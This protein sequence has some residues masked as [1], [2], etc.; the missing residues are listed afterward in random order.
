MKKHIL[1]IVFILF[2]LGNIAAQSGT[3]QWINYSQKYYKFPVT[4]NGIYKISYQTLFNAGINVNAINPLNFQVFGRGQE[5]YIF[6]N[7]EDDEIFD[8][9]DYILVYGQKNDGYF[10]NRMFKDTLN[11]PNPYY[12]MV[13]D[14]SYYFVT[15][16]SSKSNRRIIEDTDNN[17]TGYTAS[18]YFNFEQVQ[19]LS[20]QY[21]GGSTTAIDTYLPSYSAGEGWVGP[22]MYYSQSQSYSFST[23]S[24]YAPG[25]NGI[26]EATVVGLTNDQ[27]NWGDHKLLVSFNNALKSDT[28]YE[29]HASLKFKYSLAPA[30]WSTTSTLKV[31]SDGTYTDTKADRSAVGYVK[32]KYPR[33]FDLGNSTSI[34]MEIMNGVSNKAYLLM[35]NFNNQSSTAWIFDLTN[36]YK[37][38]VTK[39]GGFY[40]ALVPNTVSSNKKCLLTTE[41][42]F[43]NV[44][45]LE[46]AIY[47]SNIFTNYRNL[48]QINGGY[49]YYILTVKEFKT[50]A[51]AYK[52]YRNSTGYKAVVIDIE[53][54]YMQYS[55]GIRKHPMAI[56]SFASD[57][58]K[59]WGIKPQYFFLMG[60]SIQPGVPDSKKASFSQDNSSRRNPTNYNLNKIPTFGYPGSDVFLTAQISDS[61]L[62]DPDIPLGRIS[63]TTGAKITEY[64]SKVQEYEAN[65]H[66]YWMKR[67]LHFGGGTDKA[68]GDQFATY[69]NYYKSIIEDTCF[70]GTVNTYL[71]NTTDPLQVNVS[72]SIRTNIND[73]ASIMTFFGHAYGEGFDQSIDAPESYTNQGKYPLIIANSCLIGN[74]HL[75]TTSSGS[76]T[77][78]LAPNRG[79]IGFLA[80]VSLGIPTPLNQYSTELYRNL[81]KKQYGKGIGKIM[82]GAIRNVQKPDNILLSDDAYIEDVC[83]MMTL[84]CDPAIVINSHTK[85]DYTLYGQNGINQPMVSVNPTEV[86]SELSSF[87]INMDIANIGKAI[88]DSL[89][90]R[91][92]RKFPNTNAPD[93]IYYKKIGGVKYKT[94]LQ[95]SLPVDLI[96]GVGTNHFSILVDSEYAISELD[97]TNNQ[98]D[99]DINIRS[100]D[101]IPV[102]PYQYAIVPKKSLVLKASTINPLAPE[103]KYIFQIDT[104]SNFSSSSPLFY[105]AAITKSGG[106]VSW[107][108]SD[109]PGLANVFNSLSTNTT[110]ATPTVFFWR[111]SL[112]STYT[113]KFNWKYSSF[114][115]VQ[116][117][118]GWG[119]AHYQQIDDDEFKFIEHDDNARSFS[120]LQHVSQ[121][122]ASTS[123]WLTAQTTYKIDGALQGYWSLIGGNLL[124]VAV[125]DQYALEPWEV[126][127]KPYYNQINYK[128]SY[129]VPTWSDK[130]YWYRSDR[131]DDSTVTG[132][133]KLINDANPG[134]YILMYNFRY[135]LFKEN[136]NNHGANGATFKSTL[137]ALG[138]SVDSLNNY[139][140]SVGSC[141]YPYILIAQKGNLSYT[142]EKFTDGCGTIG[143]N[144]SMTNNWVN[145]SI[146]SPAIG[147]A[148]KWSSLHWE[149]QSNEI[150]NL[151]DTLIL[152]VIGIDANNNETVIKSYV[153]PKD[154][155]LSLD[156]LVDASK[157]P[158]MRLESYL[159]DDSMHTPRQLK[160]M[161]V[162]Y[163][164]VTEI[165]VSPNIV[166]SI[167]SDSVQ[168]G[169]DY[170]M[171]LA[172]TNVSETDADTLQITYWFSDA[173]LTSSTKQYKLLP[174]IKAGNFY[175]DTVVLST[176]ELNG[177][178]HMWY[179][180]NPYT[181][182]RPWQAE[183]YHFNNILETHFSV[184]PDKTNP[185]LDVAFDGV[186]IIN[187]DIV[188][189]TALISIQL[190]DEN[191]FLALD[192]ASL[193]QIYIK[194]PNGNITTLDSSKYTFYPGSL[195]E[196]KSK[197]EIKGDYKIEG[198][199]EL[200]IR[201]IDRSANK[202]GK[203]DGNYDYRIEFEIVLKSSITN[204]LNWPNPFTTS[205]QFVFTLT[206]SELP[207]EFRIKIMTITGKVVKEITMDELGPI[208]IGRNITQYKWNGT[209]EFGD[210][211]AN[212]VYLYSVVAKVNGQEI[213]NR[214]VSLSTNQGTTNLED[215]YFKKGFGKIYIMR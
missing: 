110:L 10:D 159:S 4:A 18:P 99:F 165:A 51:E 152:K 157:Y 86:T 101:I 31:E 173:S 112:D 78:V 134:D 84:H 89:T 149:S 196:N 2:G 11:N 3:N 92:I 25:G 151:K 172:L 122:E 57:I 19:S 189:P 68:Q 171:T 108:P 64:L 186:H 170:R 176:L 107:D 109:D 155:V 81:S 130:I 206:G 53:E 126:N 133:T 37:L 180:A 88:G 198:K 215:K 14:T 5:Q 209:D 34:E 185:L 12:S 59:N 146:K 80:S 211:L 142:K 50:E 27:S 200:M 124:M 48:S 204:I 154:D 202:S 153:S 103:R 13:N 58:L 96:N 63:V 117:K 102:Y 138:A 162:V 187:G 113:H 197:I 90:V 166:F 6:I 201:A 140:G 141:P 77:W 70:G 28:I 69:L 46:P 182:P 66:A 82:Q 136:F 93:T 115:Y 131:V 21:S 135:P 205:T 145:G 199:Y 174:P 17:Y 60:K 119:Q 52:T 160:R 20:N 47:N 74:I 43:I 177:S 118:S 114:Q 116:G 132:I 79:S 100:G 65:P 167:P 190:K 85:P 105:E 208:N 38:P 121:L 106:V 207:D 62:Y 32:M 54:L 39:S 147:P 184:Y 67:V 163:D 1:Y 87:T 123:S 104:N 175:V 212:G 158:Y 76:E 195:P 73:G 150:N 94:S 41:A 137:Q 193:F 111:V 156:T 183:Q 22:T 214:E 26:V 7:G 127:K 125:I 192:N 33:S 181:G 169:N 161:Q 120:F 45:A 148:M 128:N 24:Y 139:I 30:E 129:V 42:N 91:I 15:Y 98:Y 29:G 164:E 168:E 9:A 97:E 55:D 143:L 144:S 40:K 72:D 71:K 75:P 61:S 179:E 56:R 95:F 35:S 36:H 23:P 16:N 83:M 178:N 8:P 191:Q 194:D 203:G 213:D 188:S 49:D 210:V 44:G